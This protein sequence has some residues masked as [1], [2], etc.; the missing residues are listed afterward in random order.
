M[1]ERSCVRRAKAVYQTCSRSSSKISSISRRNDPVAPCQLALELTG[2]P[3]GIAERDPS[4]CNFRWI[5]VASDRLSGFRSAPDG[6]GGRRGGGASSGSS[7]RSISRNRRSARSR[8]TATCRPTSAGAALSQT[9]A[10]GTAGHRLQVLVS[11][12]DLLSQWLPNV[13]HGHGA[14]VTFGARLEHP[15]RRRCARPEHTSVR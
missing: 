11:M 12:R 14:V 5:E 6:R 10:R 15:C 3:A 7:V 4:S 9:Q 2:R 8:R 13:S 1:P